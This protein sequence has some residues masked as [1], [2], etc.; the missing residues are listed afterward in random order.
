MSIT[1]ITAVKGEEAMTDFQFKAIMAMVFDMLEKCKT[2][3]D[4]EETKKAIAKL[5]GDLIATDG[6]PLEKGE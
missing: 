5:C 1:A 3:E 2:I 4:V 6:K